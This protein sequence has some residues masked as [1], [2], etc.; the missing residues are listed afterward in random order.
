MKRKWK[1]N[2]WSN[3]SWYCQSE[4]QV[5]EEASVILLPCCSI[6]IMSML[7]FLISWIDTVSYVILLSTER[8][9]LAGVFLVYI[10]LGTT[11]Y[12]KKPH[13]TIL[14]SNKRRKP[15]VEKNKTPTMKTIFFKKKNY[16]KRIPLCYFLCK[17]NSVDLCSGNF[18][19]AEAE[20]L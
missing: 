15:N 5:Y 20:G 10:R 17:N 9:H 3:E 16:K 1:Q 19:D 6:A 7:R 14:L 11:K 8:L 12:K 13:R 18:Y 4:Q 2:S